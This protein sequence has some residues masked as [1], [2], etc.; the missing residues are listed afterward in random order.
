MI[1]RQKLDFVQSVPIPG[2]FKM[3]FWDC[4]DTVI[5]EKLIKRILDYGDIADIKEIYR[6]YPE[7]TTHLVFKYSDI[8]RGIKFW[9][10]LWNSTSGNL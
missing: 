9:I 10:K 4:E 3:L 2:Q 5:L 1:Q 6:M 7:E 8:R